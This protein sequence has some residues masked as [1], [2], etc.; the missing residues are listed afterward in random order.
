MPRILEP[1]S[2]TYE[3]CRDRLQEGGLVAFPTETVYGLGASLLSSKGIQRVFDT[4]QRL[5]TNPLIVHV[6]SIEMALSLVSVTKE[7]EF[8]FL[9]LAKA[10][11]PGPLTFILTV[12]EEMVPSL[13]RA[14]KPAVAVRMPNHLIARKLIE[15]CG[16][17]LVAPSAN[18]S[19]HVSPTK[20]IH[21]AEEFPDKEDL[22]IIKADSD[23]FT[24]TCRYGI[25]ST[26]LKIRKNELEILRP[27]AISLSAIQ[28]CLKGFL[29]DA[30]YNISYESSENHKGEAPGSLL[31]HYCPRI[32][33]FIIKNKEYFFSSLLLKNN[34]NFSLIG[35][36]D[37]GNMFEEELV[38]K[39]VY[40]K[41]L[42]EEIGFYRN[43]SL[44]GNIEEA[45]SHL[46]AF[47]REAEEYGLECLYF[48]FFS[49]DVEEQKGIYDRIYRACIG[50]CV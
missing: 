17:P 19:G 21:V 48:P 38:L 32:S 46:F 22:I 14:G 39:S 30:S 15:T 37:F 29:I 26:I 43:L 47:M 42:K 2:S 31:A 16:I 45:T 6:S 44:S 25:E 49:P 12:K 40:Q 18:V 10:F 23:S 35:I 8:I 34:I 11:W 5:K 20:A 28:A 33:C 1:T 50:H 27:G 24:E 36:L 4:K 7:E 3:I 41:T 13:A 9:T